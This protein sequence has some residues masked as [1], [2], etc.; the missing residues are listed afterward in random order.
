MRL[1]W[2]TVAV[3]VGAVKT[4]AAKASGASTHGE[5]A[6]AIGRVT[7]ASPSRSRCDGSER[8]IA[9]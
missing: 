3:I 1:S 5:G 8:T 4:P 2:S 9:P 6:S 7:R